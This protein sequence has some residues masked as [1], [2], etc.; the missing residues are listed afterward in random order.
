MFS[1][2]NN[3]Q[4]RTKQIR[5]RV[6]RKAAALPPDRQSLTAVYALGIR[7]GLKIAA[8]IREKTHRAEEVQTNE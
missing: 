1:K 2:S 4:G 8:D 6:I 5:R 7:D 3:N